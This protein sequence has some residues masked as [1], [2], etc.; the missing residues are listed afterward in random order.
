MTKYRIKSYVDYYGDTYYVAEFKPKWW[1][2]WQEDSFHYETE[3]EALDHIQE[4]KILEAKHQAKKNRKYT[5]K[6]IK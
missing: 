3:K 4:W 5:Y 2:Q 6:E 1:S